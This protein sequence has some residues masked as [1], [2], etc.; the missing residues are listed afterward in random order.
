M[1]TSSAVGLTLTPSVNASWRSESEVQTSN[2]SFYDA[3]ITSSTGAVFPSN[4][5][6]DGPYIVGSF[7]EDRWIVNATLTLASTAGWSL[8]AECRN[9]FDQEAIESALAGFSYLNPPRTWTVR[10]K[11]EF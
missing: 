5:F 7:S 9:C 6:G 10:A 4:P 8:A 3:P 11:Y 2:L 1:Q